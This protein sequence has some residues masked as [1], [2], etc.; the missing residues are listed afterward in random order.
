M[1]NTKEI[2]LERA[3]NL[4]N[5]KGVEYGG[6]RELAK[7]LD[8]RVSNISYYFPTK[9]LLVDALTAKLAEL[10]ST[11][12][13]KYDSQSLKNYLEMQRAMFQ[14]QY[15]YRCLPMSFVHLFI[16]N[17][18][19]AAN[20][21]LTE[22]KR[23]KQLEEIF[24]RLITN[25]YLDKKTTAVDVQMMIDH[26]ALIARFWLSEARISHQDKTIDQTIHHYFT[27][28]CDILQQ[29]TTVKGKKD[30]KEFLMGISA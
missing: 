22:K 12:V 5:E 25:G 23:R 13:Q 2:I 17:P 28:I 24:S 3:L 20:Y 30:I 19:T 14:N 29:H 27:L 10:N 4:F 7:L 26:I 8:I 1:K 16:N 6:M 15:M 11:T 21:K 9:D 18:T